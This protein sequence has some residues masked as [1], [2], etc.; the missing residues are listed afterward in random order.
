MFN[1]DRLYDITLSYVTLIYIAL[2]YI[3]YAYDILTATA[4][5]FQNNYFYQKNIPSPVEKLSLVRLGNIKK[6]SQLGLEISK[7]IPKYVLE[8][9]EIYP[10]YVLKLSTIYPQYVLELS[11]K[12]PEY[13]LVAMLTIAKIGVDS[14]RLPVGSWSVQRT[15]CRKCQL[16]ACRLHHCFC[17][18][19]PKTFT[20]LHTSNTVL[21]CVP[22]P[23]SFVSCLK[24]S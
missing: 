21:F 5:G 20:R 1:S 23:H 10:K 9:S 24:M 14:D 18:G 16:Y 11:K 3:H 8:L 22:C 4:W 19:F 17:Y 13:V 15:L 7:T 2:H 6:L 12:Y